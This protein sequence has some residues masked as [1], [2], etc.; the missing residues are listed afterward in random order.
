MMGQTR[1]D[2]S[3]A[4]LPRTWYNINADL[5]TPLPPPLHP[6]TQ[7]PVD[8]EFMSTISPRGLIAQDV[9]TE[10]EIEIPTP[11]RDLYKLWRPTPLLRAYRLEQALGTPAHIYYKYE[12]V[13]PVG[14]HKANTAV[15]Q[16]F[17]LKD[18]GGKAFTTETGA[19]QWGSAL[20]MGCNFFGLGC[21]IYMVRISY[22]QKPFRRFVMESYGA[23]VFASPS[24]RTASGRKFLAIDPE[25]PGSLGMAISEGIEAA[26]TSGGAKKYSL[27]S[28]LPHVLLHQTVI[29]EECL[30]QMAMA[31]EYPDVV[32]GCAG[33]GSNFAGIAFPFLRENFRHGRRTRI[34]AVEPAACPTLTRGTYTWDWADAAGIAPICK[35]YTLGHG[36]VPPGIH[37]GGLRYHG[38]APQVS[39]LLAGGHIEAQ[40]YDQ[41]DIFESGVLFGRA[42]GV[43]PAPESN[44]A[45]HA[46]IVEARKCIDTGERKVILFNLSGHGNFDMMSYDAFLQGKLQRYDHPQAAI[47][48]A[49]KDL[50]RVAER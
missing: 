8:V 17:Y 5:P 46:A 33:G 3:E 47:D 6:V 30:K 34:V 39:A 9:A 25:H 48:A 16:A 40:A 35:I 32:I 14:S 21:E 42:E 43:L 20:S 10:P 13:S 26:A 11:V 36:F 4:E 18:D 15:A 7:Q 50:P 27:G 12:G 28:F 29:G 23:Q 24:D 2:L 41:V 38:M 1:F 31:D 45:V 49:L 19:G 22:N 37:A 44:H